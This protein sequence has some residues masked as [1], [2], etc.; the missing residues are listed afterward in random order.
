MRK[1]FHLLLASMVGFGLST[2]RA[3]ET[4]NVGIDFVHPERFTDFRIQGRQEIESAQIFR[5][6][7]SSYLSPFVARRFPDATLS[8]RFSDI[9][10]A[11]RLEPWRIRKFNDV[12][13]DFDGSPLR[14]Y[15]EYTL[16]DSKGRGLASGSKGLAE[17][18][19]LNR[20]IGYPSSEKVSILF[21]EKVTLSRWL[22]SLTLSGSHFTGK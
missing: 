14:L 3:A 2:A 10:L 5:D 17:S 6:Q 8:L 21:Y 13:F 1:L 22:S 4:S 12:R 16:T 15:F 7:I 18:Y 19:Y 20:Y 9:D 11:G